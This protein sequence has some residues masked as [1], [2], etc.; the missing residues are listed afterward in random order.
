MFDKLFT[1]KNL[2]GVAVALVIAVFTVLA[3]KFLGGKTED[4]P[5]E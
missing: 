3:A 2:I 5:S 1:K 4:V